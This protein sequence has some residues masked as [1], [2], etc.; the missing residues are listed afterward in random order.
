[1]SNH[2]IEMSIQLLRRPLRASKLRWLAP[3]SMP[4][5]LPSGL[6]GLNRDAFD[7]ARYQRLYLLHVLVRAL[8]VI[9]ERQ[10]PA[11]SELLFLLV[12]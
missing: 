2:A 3:R 6:Y 10:H 4:L 11:V 9:P 1:M 12:E 5:F 8:G 7:D